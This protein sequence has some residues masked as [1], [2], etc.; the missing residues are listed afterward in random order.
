MITAIEMAQRSLKLLL[1]QAADAPLEA[2]EYQDFY[3]AMNS[4]MASLEPHGIVLGYSP[5]S[6]P[7]D[8]VTVPDSVISGLAALLAIEVAPDYERPITEALAARG[9]KGMRTLRR[10]T[11]R[12]IETKL[13]ENLPIGSGNYYQAFNSTFHYDDE[14]RLVMTLNG[15]ELE[16]TITAVDTPVK[17]KGQWQVAKAVGVLPDLTGRVKNSDYESQDYA[18]RLQIEVTGGTG[19]TAHLYENGNESLASVSGVADGS[20]VLLETSVSV[21]P[22]SFLELWIENDVDDANLIVRDAFWE[23]Q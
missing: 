19:F 22:N 9:M 8:F 4:Y 21:L 12:K 2:D 10:V 13:H 20:K 11:R 7:A 6:G 16:T 14:E 1:V 15:N 5:V 3:D 23:M 18:I 17:A